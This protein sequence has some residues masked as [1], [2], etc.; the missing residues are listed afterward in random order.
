MNDPWRARH[1]GNGYSAEW[2]PTGQRTWRILREAGTVKVF[3]TA[4]DALKAAKT[5]FL[6][7]LEPTIRATLPVDA[8]RLEQKLAAEAESFLRSN[9]QDVRNTE[10]HYRPGKKPFKAMRGR[11]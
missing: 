11:A 5:R 7:S 6:A 8:D 2:L 3:T 10:V 9:R 4:R 1:F